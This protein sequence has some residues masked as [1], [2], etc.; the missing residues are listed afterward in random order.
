MEDKYTSSAQYCGQA[1]DCRC[2]TLGFEFYLLPYKQM[3]ELARETV[4][5]LSDLLKSDFVSKHTVS[6]RRVSVD[7]A[8]SLLIEKT[9]QGYGWSYIH[10]AFAISPRVY[11]SKTMT[12]YMRDMLRGKYLDPN[13]EL[14]VSVDYPAFWDSLGFKKGEDP[15]VLQA[16]A[17]QIFREPARKHVTQYVLPDV[18]ALLSVNTYENK[19]PAFWGGFELSINACCLN[20]VLDNMADVFSLFAKKLSEKYTN[21]NLCVM[22]QP[23]ELSWGKSPYMRYFG[24]NGMTDGSHLD[25]DMVARE[26][27][28]SYYLSGVE[29]FNILSPLCRAHIPEV[30]ATKE[31]PKGVVGE[32]LCGGGLLLRS[33]K[34]ISDYDVA[35]ALQLKKLVYPALY[36]GR[37]HIPLRGLFS[38]DP[39]RFFAVNYPRS[40]WAIIPVLDSEV[41]IVGTDLVF[42]YVK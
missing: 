13:L 40:N 23:I 41:Y 17:L 4:L 8:L 7:K 35:D 18:N 2:L 21:L 20:N 10:E 6:N 28:P 27:Y 34:T 12:D 36:P 26:W 11:N 5:W 29:W 37:S 25:M 32:E 38:N 22:L 31:L 9:Q 14:A 30:T 16:K 3:I 19:R 24:R 15:D 33:A 42:S 1:I 39:Y